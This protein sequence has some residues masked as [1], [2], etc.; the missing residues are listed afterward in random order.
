MIKELSNSSVLSMS[1][2]IRYSGTKVLHQE[3]LAE[4]SYY[5]VV[6]SD[7][8][9][10]DIKERFP[11]KKIDSSKVLR[12]ALY[13]DYEEVSTWDII[14]P[15]KEASSE[16]R[17][18]LWRVWQMLMKESLNSEYWDKY[19]NVTRAITEPFHEHKINKESKLES[20]I[21]KFADML[22]AF[23]YNKTEVDLW[24]LCFVPVL[25]AIIDKWDKSRIFNKYVKEL[26]EIVN[27]WENTKQE[28]EEINIV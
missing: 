11:L 18:E 14:T 7:L 12:Y 16:L 23:M 26:I 24:N 27:E 1:N 28:F 19:K 3:N 4:H 25:E 13:Y 15:V 20:R 22:Q 17:K 5:V 2:V 21:V 10:S 6:L 8:L 9:L